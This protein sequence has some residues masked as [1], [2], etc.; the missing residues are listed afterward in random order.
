MIPEIQRFNSSYERFLNS[1]KSERISAESLNKF[2]ARPGQPLLEHVSNMFKELISYISTIPVFNRPYGAFI[3]FGTIV[4]ILCHDIGKLLPHFQYKIAA[5]SNRKDHEPIP[6]ELVKYSYHTLFSACFSDLLCNKLTELEQIDELVIDK[7]KKLLRYLTCEAILCHHSSRLLETFSS[8]INLFINTTEDDQFENLNQYFQNFTEFPDT[9]IESFLVETINRAINESN[10]QE[11]TDFIS[12]MQTYIPSIKTRNDFCNY[13]KKIIQETYQEFRKIYLEKAPSP[14]L[15]DKISFFS[16]PD[17]SFPFEKVLE[18]QQLRKKILEYFKDDDRE[19]KNDSSTSTMDFNPVDIYILQSYISSLL[20]DLDIW[21]ARFHARNRK[22]LK[23]PFFERRPQLSLDIIEN[24]VSHPFGVLSRDYKQFI[25]NPKE[26]I[27]DFLRNGLFEEARRYEFKDDNNIFILNSPT[28]AGKTLCLLNMAVKSITLLKNPNSENNSKNFIPKIIY[29][30]PFVSIGTQVAN[31]IQR[32][33]EPEKK[34]LINSDL[35][36]VDNYTTE[37]LWTKSDHDDE[38]LV[39]EGAD[40]RWLIV[41]WRSQYII[42]TFVKLFHALLKPMKINYLKFHR[43]AHSIIILDEVQCLPIRY[44]EAIKM[45]LSSMSKILNCIIFLSTATQ[46]AILEP[47]KVISIAPKHL[48]MLI[49]TENNQLPL[50][51]ALNRYKILFFSKRIDLDTFLTY[52]LKFL[53]KYPED[54]VLLVVNTK[55]AA[56]KAYKFLLQN[57]K[58]LNFDITMLSTLVLP[59]DRKNSI[60]K[61]KEQKQRQ[62][63]RNVVISTQVIEAGVDISFKYVFRDLAPL[64][65]IIQIAGRCNRYFEFENG[66]QIRIFEFSPEKMEE[67]SQNKLKTYFQQVYKTT[68]ADDITKEFLRKASKLIQGDDE[69]FQNDIFGEYYTIDEPH[70]RSEFQFYFN[71]IKEYNNYFEGCNELI[72]L[73]YET[74]ASDFTIIESYKNQI[75]VFLVIDEVSKKLH[76]KWINGYSLNSKFFLYS[77]LLNKKWLNDLKNKN[78]VKELIINEKRLYFYIEKGKLREYYDSKSGFIIQ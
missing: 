66:G 24:Y 10:S 40:A 70:L 9:L 22:E 14:I 1:I 76:E 41:S 54:D 78:V 39:F 71:E 4:A 64:D 63:T 16:T 48:E 38:N 45:L 59:L 11:V 77:I 27:M 44:W 17:I 73:K 36:T 58:D 8:Q 19:T 55:S 34:E 7:N 30:L 13:F 43:I 47:D 51:K 20:C 62:C 74:L 56:I 5:F 33:F 68:G 49:T 67:S 52:F 15:E 69:I 46:P 3:Y 57:K 37:N 53:E 29:A 31:Q 23:L 2:L 65:S 12:L 18:I 6:P 28:G 50:S 32:I 42:T 26:K 75:P 35:I 61:L 60:Q 72:N 21:D 25:P